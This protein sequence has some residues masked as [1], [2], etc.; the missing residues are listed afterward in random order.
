MHFLA[1]VTDKRCIGYRMIFIPI[2][3]YLLNKK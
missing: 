2:F 1:V 3:I